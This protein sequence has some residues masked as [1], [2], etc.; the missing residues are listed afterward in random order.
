MLIW[1]HTYWSSRYIT[2]SKS[3][4]SCQYSDKCHC[5][6]VFHKFTVMPLLG[7]LFV[8]SAHSQMMRYR[9]Y[10]KISRL[11]GKVTCNKTRCVCG[12]TICLRPLQVD[13]IFVFICQL[14][15]VPACWLFKTSATSWPFVLESGVIGVGVMCDVGYLCANFILPRPL[16]SRVRPDVH[17]KMSDRQT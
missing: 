6:L 10:H 8:K 3:Q 9:L 14:A 17:N 15:P 12:D 11:I 13:N 4:F 5:F 1:F 2:V 16:C 7:W